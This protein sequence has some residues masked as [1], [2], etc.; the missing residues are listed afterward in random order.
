MVYMVCLG[1]KEGPF[2]LLPSHSGRLRQGDFYISALSVHDLQACGLLP[3]T[4]VKHNEIPA[5]KHNLPT[6]AQFSGQCL[7]SSVSASQPAL[8]FKL[9]YLWYVT[10]SQHPY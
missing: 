3:G 9:L 6:T 1:R 8:V 2:Q 5:Q 10:V 4:L 7:V